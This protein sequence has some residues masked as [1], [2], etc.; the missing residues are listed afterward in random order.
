MLG[1]AFL[2]SFL[3]IIAL[4]KIIFVIG[5]PLINFLLFDF[6]FRLLSLFFRLTHIAKTGEIKIIIRGVSLFRCRWLFRW[7]F[8]LFL[9]VFLWLLFLLLFFLAWLLCLLCL[10]LFCFKFLF[11]LFLY[12]LFYFLLSFHNN[13]NWILRAHFVEFIASVMQNIY[14][15]PTFITILLQLF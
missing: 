6:D 1:L 3:F 14:C 4:L 11:D 15:Y 7:R 2:P 8:L 9:F 13:F 5:K 12:F 10:F